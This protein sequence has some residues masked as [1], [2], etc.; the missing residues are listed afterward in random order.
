MIEKRKRPMDRPRSEDL[1]WEQLVIELRTAQQREMSSLHDAEACF[2]TA[3]VVTLPR[4]WTQSISAAVRQTLQRRATGQIGMADDGYSFVADTWDYRSPDMVRSQIV[5]QPHEHGFGLE[6]PCDEQ[7]ILPACRTDT[8]NRWT[9]LVQ[10]APVVEFCTATR[11]VGPNEQ[12]LLATA[13]RQWDVRTDPS[14]EY[15]ENTAMAAEPT[16]AADELGVY[17]R[18]HWWDN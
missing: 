5:S 11:M 16:D 15:W 1:A 17:L 10:H 13:A 9:D 7:P 18:Q 6:T 8:A 2:R 12:Q 4:A 3:P 14:T